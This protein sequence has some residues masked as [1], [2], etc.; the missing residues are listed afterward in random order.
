MVNM[1]LY[2]TTIIFILCLFGCSPQGN[3]LT[4]RE[5]P[6]GKTI[7]YLNLKIVDFSGRS[8]T[9]NA[10]NSYTKKILRDTTF[11]DNFKFS[12]TCG[13]DNSCFKGTPPSP[14]LAAVDNDKR[15]YVTDNYNAAFNP[16]NANSSNQI[17]MIT[18]DDGSVKTFC[19]MTLLSFNYKN[20]GQNYLPSED[21]AIT[22]D[23]D[24]RS[25]PPSTQ[26]A[27]A[28]PGSGIKYRDVSEIQ[29]GENLYAFFKYTEDVQ[30]E[31]NNSIGT[32]RLLFSKVN[33][34]EGAPP[35]NGND[36]TNQA[37]RFTIQSATVVAPNISSL[38]Y[39]AIPGTGALPKQHTIFFNTQDDENAANA[40]TSADR[41][42]VFTLDS[43]MTQ[44]LINNAF[45]PLPTDLS[46]AQSVF[47][48]ANGNMLSFSNAADELVDCYSNTFTALHSGNFFGV[49]NQWNSNIIVPIVGSPTPVTLASPTK[50]RLIVFA[51][52]ATNTTLGAAKRSSRAFVLFK[53]PVTTSSPTAW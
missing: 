33:S 9:T 19:R 38:I 23:L 28:N 2:L 44:M 22:I 51:S 31:N 42:R 21:S 18:E 27:Y 48:N 13:N 11:A 6:E 12:I 24:F 37:P 7:R 4:V 39:Q 45:V 10:L 8:F 26:T 29:V 14:K 52:D 30:T 1:K 47:L 5:L 25:S 32:V 35:D 34:A 16:D 50:P 41:C 49:L 46:G 15:C 53:I 17:P 40:L 20:L 36:I 43:T 3:K